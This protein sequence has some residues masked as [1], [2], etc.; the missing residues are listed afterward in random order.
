MKVQ[1]TKVESLMFADYVLVWMI[2]MSSH[3]VSAFGQIQEIVL[4][5][6][7]RDFHIHKWIINL[8]KAIGCGYGIYTNEQE[9]FGKGNNKHYQLLVTSSNHLLVYVC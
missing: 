3:V 1:R 7:L 5:C 4:I 8:T 2:Y 6:L 9:R